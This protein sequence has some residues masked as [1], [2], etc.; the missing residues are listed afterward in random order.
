M[1]NLNE[2]D[3]IDLG[4]KVWEKNGIK[5]IYIKTDS[6]LKVIEKYEIDCIIEQNLDVVKK[7]NNNQTYFC[8]KNNRFCSEKRSVDAFLE[9]YVNNELKIEEV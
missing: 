6:F 7:M 3:I 4:G 2:K 5:R 1:K 8:F 9:N